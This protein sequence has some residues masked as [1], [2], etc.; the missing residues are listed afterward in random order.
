MTPIVAPFEVSTGPC[1]LERRYTNA[2]RSVLPRVDKQDPEGR[3]FFDHSN[4]GFV[5][6]SCQRS[7]LQLRDTLNSFVVP[8]TPEVQPVTEVAAP[9]VEQLDIAGYLAGETPLVGIRL[10]SVRDGSVLSISLSHVVADEELIASLPKMP[11]PP[12]SFE[13]CV[14]MG[15]YDVF[16]NIK[17]EREGGI[18]HS[19][20]VLHLPGVALGHL[21]EQVLASRTAEEQGIQSLTV[22]DIMAA[23]LWIAREAAEGNDLSHGLKRCMTYAVDL[24]RASAVTADAAHKV[25]TDF[26]GNAVYAQIVMP[27][28]APT[29]IGSNGSHSQAELVRSVLAAAVCAVH[30]GTQGLRA[31]P[32]FISKSLGSHSD[33]EDSNYWKD[34]LVAPGLV[35]FRDCAGMSSSWRGGTIDKVDFGQGKPWLVAG[36]IVPLSQVSNIMSNGP[37]GDGA[38][39]TAAFRNGGHQRLIDSRILELIDPKIVLM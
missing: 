37:G 38:L 26:W 25:P 20:H 12:C 31:D 16:S 14:E 33:M 19:H 7:D 39:Y 35:P 28:P 29:T 34:L 8:S 30:A 5:F 17:A 18:T 1:T 22:H 23:T 15:A 36:K 2:R 32:N 21:R 6:S 4:S 13:D 10:T 27:P 24:R 9:F 3:T 11:P